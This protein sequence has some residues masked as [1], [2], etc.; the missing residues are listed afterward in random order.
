MHYD[1]LAALRRRLYVGSSV[2]V[3]AAFGFAAS[4]YAADP[5]KA[6]DTI[7]TATPIKHLVIIVGE[8]RSFDHLFATYVPQHPQEGIHNLLSEGIVT[9]EGQPG[10][11]FD[12][13]HQY[14]ITAPPNHG[15]YFVSADLAQKTLYATLPPPD[16]N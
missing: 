6:V 9:A 16:L 4:A 5:D 3:L 7:P 12:R 11:H 14:R 15:K 13:A 8:N 1:S 2:S 10:P